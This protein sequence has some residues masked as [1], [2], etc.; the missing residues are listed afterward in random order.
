MANTVKEVKDALKAALAKLEE[1]DENSSCVIE[2][3]DNCGK[4]YNED[5]NS[6]TFNG[7]F[8]GTVYINNF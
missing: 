8:D 2:I 5:I 7:V 6:F 1:F 4:Y 3:K